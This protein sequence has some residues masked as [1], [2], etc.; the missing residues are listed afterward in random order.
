MKV[1]SLSYK[2]CLYSYRWGNRFRY[3]DEQTG[4][5]I[6]ETWS[7]ESVEFKEFWNV[8]LSSLKIHLEEK[9]WFE[10]AYLGINENELKSN[11]GC[12]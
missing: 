2:L 4:N 5:Y 11:S 7:P 9:G 12:Y 3:L 1:G 10:K 8:F 6:Y